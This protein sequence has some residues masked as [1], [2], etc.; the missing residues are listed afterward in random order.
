MTEKNMWLKLRDQLKSQCHITRI[1]NAISFGTPD[2]HI[3]YRNRGL[4]VELKI[5]K[6]GH[7]FLVQP[8]QLAWHFSRLKCQC[9]DSFFLVYGVNASWLLFSAGQVVQCIV[10]I[11]NTIRILMN[12]IT[13]KFT[14]LF[15]GSL[16]EILEIMHNE[17][18]RR[19]V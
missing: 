16:P 1:E 15:P 10:P 7:Y 14:G 12:A 9:Y 13:P 2:V 5:E 19:D 3:G 8:S 18:S 4:W 11:G 17:T 6:P